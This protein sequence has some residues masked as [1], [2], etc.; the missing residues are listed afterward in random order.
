MD[1]LEDKVRERQALVDQSLQQL[2]KTTGELQLAQKQQ[3]IDNWEKLFCAT[4]AHNTHGRR[5]KFLIQPLKTSIS[6]GVFNFN[7]EVVL[8]RARAS[9]GDD[10]EAILERVAKQSKRSQVS[11]YTKLH[12]NLFSTHR[13]AH[14]HKYRYSL[15][16]HRILFPSNYSLSFP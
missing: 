3:V 12:S 4:E 14:Y 16:T 2:Q 10:I 15:P 11:L 8:E 7:P 9:Q 6:G 13:D 1:Q 5:W